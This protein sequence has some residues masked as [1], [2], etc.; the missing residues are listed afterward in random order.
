MPSEKTFTFF[1]L[2]KK[3]PLHQKDIKIFCHT[4]KFS[5]V[6]YCLSAFYP[7]PFE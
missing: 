7:M 5:M 3:V 6:L 4:H 1:Y 2:F